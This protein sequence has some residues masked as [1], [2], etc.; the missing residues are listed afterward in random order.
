MIFDG[1]EGE[2]IYEK[3]CMRIRIQTYLKARTFL[4]QKV[5]AFLA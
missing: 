3:I 4:L 1:K 5:R 2:G